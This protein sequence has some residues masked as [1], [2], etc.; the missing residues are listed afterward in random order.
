MNAQESL[1]LG[2]DA[3]GFLLPSDVISLGGGGRGG[4]MVAAL[5]LAARSGVT[6]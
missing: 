6:S 3:L 1:G 5:D 4:L 2:A